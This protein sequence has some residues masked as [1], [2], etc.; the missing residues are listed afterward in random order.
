MLDTFPDTVRLV[1]KPF[2]PAD[3]QASWLAASAV[4]AAHAQGHFWEFR[5][6][7]FLLEDP[8]SA[9]DLRDIAEHIEMDVPRFY[10]DLVSPAIQNLLRQCINDGLDSNVTGTPTILVD[11]TPVEPLT[12]DNLSKAIRSAVQP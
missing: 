6:Q 4:L 7:L 9:N 10:R 12:I 11:Q 8:V 3:R 5:E 2:P 1:V